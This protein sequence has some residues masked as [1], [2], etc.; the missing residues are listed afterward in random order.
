MKRF[1]AHRWQR[2]G[3]I[4]RYS[5]KHLLC[6]QGDLVRVFQKEHPSTSVSEP[7][8]AFGLTLVVDYLRRVGK[9][10]SLQPFKVQKYKGTDGLR[11]GLGNEVSGTND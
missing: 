8:P 1:V 11:L 5:A 7:Y 10:F 2:I 9:M 3:Q 4:L 6:S